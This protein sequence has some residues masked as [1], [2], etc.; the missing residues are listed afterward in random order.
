MAVFLDLFRSQKGTPTAGKQPDLAAPAAEKIQSEL[1]TDAAPKIR[2]I[3]MGTPEFAATLLSGL[4]ESRYHIICVLTKPDTPSGRKQEVVESAVKRI[5]LEHGL[6]VEQPHKLDQEAIEKIKNLHPDLIIVAAYGKILP[7]AILEIPGFGC[8]NAHASLLPEWRG[9]SPIQ[10]ALLSGATE[11]GVTIM[12][13]DEGMDTGAILTQQKVSIDPHETRESLLPRVTEAARELLLKTVP[14]LV[15]RTITAIPQD[16]AHA[17]LCQLIE[18]EDGHIIWMD[19]AE[20][21]Y[22]RYRA[23][24]PWPGIFSF[25]KKDNEQLRLKLHR[26][27]YQQQSLETP[28]P[29]GSLFE[30]EGKVGVQTGAGVIFLEEVQLEGK[31]RLPIETFLL[32]N[33]D[34][35]GSLLQ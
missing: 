15:N 25:W 8:I 5:A 22:N 20:T 29:I 33:K 12:L 2:V 7:K 35:I 6:P 27:S 10:N 9:A 14:L 3:F 24:S 30:A 4:I 13:M 34:I 28:L 17:T 31:T 16:N 18:R 26:I 32:G 19:E 11:T 21:I 1:P 23:L